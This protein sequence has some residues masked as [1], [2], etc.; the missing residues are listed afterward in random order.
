MG[1]RGP[2]PGTRYGGRKKGT[3]NK[4]TTAKLAILKTV[5]AEFKERNYNPLVEMIKLAQKPKLAEHDPIRFSF[6]K[7]LAM[8]YFP[9]VIGV[10]VDAKVSIEERFDTPEKRQ[11][12]I[13]ELV[14]ELKRHQPQPLQLLQGMPDGHEG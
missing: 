7:E 8:K 5:E 1:Q 2:K 14:A 11:A 4:G 13:A 12:R 10:K 3:P 9:N 6:H